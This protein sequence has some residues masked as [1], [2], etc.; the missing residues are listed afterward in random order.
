M[1]AAAAAGQAT[2][3]L[4][5][6]NR[7]QV[8]EPAPPIPAA[9]MPAATEAND[10]A[11][12]RLA[13][14]GPAGG[15][16]PS[17]SR[18]PRARAEDDP[19]TSPSFARG[20]GAPEDSR[21]YGTPR[22]SA[23]EEPSGSYPVPSGTAYPS[24]PDSY[25]RAGSDYS[26]SYPGGYPSPGRDTYPG[27]RRSRD[28]QARDSYPDPSAGYEA[29]S[30]G[31]DGSRDYPASGRHG[32]PA[33]QADRADPGA[34]RTDPGTPRTSP[35]RRRSTPARQVP[36]S[37]AAPAQAASAR[38]PAGPAATPTPSSAAPG[39]GSGRGAA[40]DASP[41]AGLSN[42]YGSYVD[43]S[44][45]VPPPSAPAPRASSATPASP[46]QPGQQPAGGS[47]YPG[48]TTGPTAA[49]SDPYSPGPG[50][51]PAGGPHPAPDGQAEQGA[52]WYSAPPA[53]PQTPQAPA[54]AY[55]YRPDPGYPAD[56]GYGTQP[57]QAGYP[58][59]PQESRDDTRYRSGQTD[60]PYGP[61]GYSGYHSRQ[62]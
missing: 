16:P 36:P 29:Y 19:L 25:P 26:P 1:W 2:E 9:F 46:Y 60:D 61:D 42:P 12:A 7:P 51:Y 37:Q 4:Q 47:S 39:W 43:T 18:E 27:P 45:P 15:P 21:S 28:S 14:L 32:Y 6:R 23:A 59:T 24:G 38:Y 57:G 11:T 33:G 34:A 3:R 55:P 20:A 17:R 54:S 56:P 13:S 49:Y 52:T 5:V 58:G 22:G 41:A 53:A 31:P 40:D 30:G 35:G 44:P 50:G 8:A 48:Y 10:P 62:G